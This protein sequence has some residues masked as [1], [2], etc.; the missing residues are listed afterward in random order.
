MKTVLDFLGRLALNN[1]REWFVAHKE[2]YLAV[3]ATFNRFGEELLARMAEI[4]PAVAGLTL[5]DCTYR[6]YRDT[7]FSADKSPYKTHMGIFMPPGGKKSGYAGYYF[8][9]E[10][11]P[12][13]Y[14]GSHMICA[15]TYCFD[16]DVLQSIREEILDHPEEF[17]AA[18]ARAEAFELDR[19]QTLRRTPKGFPTGT[20][21]D[22]LLRLKNW[23]LA[24]YPDDQFLC[25]DSLAERVASLMATTTDFLHIVNRAMRY[26]YENR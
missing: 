8:H 3:Q 22:E 16:R 26:A 19:T 23:N 9:V 2:E 12:A 5:K 25:A 10:P 18:I 6:I 24:L 15:G 21:W 13:N 1:N 14:I 4:D 7:R 20:E 17:T 11:Q